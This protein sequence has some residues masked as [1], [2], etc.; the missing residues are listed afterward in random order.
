MEIYAIGDLHL[1]STVNKPMAIFGEKWHD[2]DQKVISFWKHN[3]SEEDIV[4]IPG[5][6]SWAMKLDEV[7]SDL[8]I[9]D[10]LPGRKIC[11]RGNHDYWWHKINHL[12]QLYDT[13]DFI[14]NT[15]YMIGRTAICG[16]RGWVCPNNRLFTEDDHKIYVREAQRLRLSLDHALKQN[17][18]EMILMMHYPPT[19]EEHDQSLF[20]Q[21]IQSYPIKHVVYGHLHDSEGQSKGIK[22]QVESVNFH[23][24]SADYLDFNVKWIDHLEV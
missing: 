6:L 9:I 13:I 2:H 23:L 22:G 1:G 11:V 17:A 19:N 21:L 16:T 20:M 3:V 4:L 18:E 12:N 14:Q 24:V 8:A 7:K 10:S 5:D 15:S